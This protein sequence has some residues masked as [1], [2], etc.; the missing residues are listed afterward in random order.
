VTV[1]KITAPEKF[2]G[3][4]GEQP[5]DGATSVR[6]GA[7]FYDKDTG[8]LYITYDGTNWVEKDTIVRLEASSTINIGDVEIVDSAGATV[9][10]AEDAAHSSGDKGI[11][12]L[13]VRNDGGVAPTSADGDYTSPQFSRIGNLRVTGS[14]FGV[15]TLAACNN[16]TATWTR[17]YTSP[18]DQKG[19]TG[20]LANLFGGV[21][22]G[23][24]W[25]RV[26]IP[27]DEM[28][29]T[30]LTTGQWTYYMNSN[31]YMGVSMVI[32]AH[33][34][35]NFANRVD[36]SQDA[37][38][39]ESAAAW[40]KHVLATSNH[41]FFYGEGVT[42]NTTCTTAGTHYTLA[43]FQ[44]DACF[45]TWTIYRITLEFGWG[46]AGNTFGNAYVADV[47]LNGNAIPMSPQI[48]E[49]ILA[50]GKRMK[51]VSVTKALAAAAIYDANDVISE[52]AA[53]GTIWTFAALAK[54]D[55]GSGYITKANIISE[56]ENVTPKLTLFLYTA[57]PTGALND[58]AANT[59]PDAADLANYIGKIDFPA[60]ESLGT[61]DST[62]M[63]TPSTSGG[64]PIAFTC[65]V[66]SDDLFGV[67]VTRD[68]FTQ[69][70][71]DDM[72]I[73]ITVEVY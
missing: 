66:A 57:A 38:D 36:I 50:V 16:S 18:L 19:S 73:R 43:Q 34:P 22:T 9:V 42:G 33:D 10:K 5:T 46:A 31:D 25:A 54:Q 8:I 69:T 45:S 37:G 49:T 72:T 47:I 51:V 68:A 62:T 35:A 21:Q 32:W 4:T 44:S 11:M 60:M 20:W 55:G 64:L 52:S 48:D 14:P 56:S 7:T 70:A 29:L 59:N 71:T 67:L 65:A 6:P 15:P 13:G 58:H 53:A 40:N 3:A 2:I 12:A 39:V 63:C 27:V 17:G 61:T 1:K 41:F 30:K 24:D 26:S 23:D 28:L